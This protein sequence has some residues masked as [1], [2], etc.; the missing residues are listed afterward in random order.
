MNPKMFCLFCFFVFFVVPFGGFFRNVIMMHFYQKLNIVIDF[1]YVK[2]GE[3]SH[4]SI[5]VFFFVHHH[6][7][8]RPRNMANRFICQQ[9]TFALNLFPSYVFK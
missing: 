1:S 3:N 9:Y 5:L 8:S 7:H 6:D 4:M 2:C